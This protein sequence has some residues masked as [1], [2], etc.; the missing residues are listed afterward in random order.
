MGNAPSTGQPDVKKHFTSIL[1]WVRTDQPRQTGMD[2]WKGPHCGIIAA[3]PALE[4]YRRIHLAEH[5][6]AC[7]P[8]PGGGDRHPG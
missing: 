1:L 6:L 3:T 4:D 7:G 5:N 8:Q 2:Y